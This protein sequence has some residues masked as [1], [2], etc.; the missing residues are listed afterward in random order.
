MVAQRAPG[1]VVARSTGAVELV[2]Q[3]HAALSADGA[4]KSILIVRIPVAVLERVAR[5]VAARAGLL[6]RVALQ[7]PTRTE[8]GHGIGH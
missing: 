1:A 5:C 2:A 6:Q 3:P 4:P 8:I 7:V